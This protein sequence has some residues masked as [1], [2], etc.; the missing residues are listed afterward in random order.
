M[1]AKDFGDLRVLGGEKTDLRYAEG[2]KIDIGGSYTRFERKIEMRGELYMFFQEGRFLILVT[3]AVKP[4]LDR[5]KVVY[6]KIRKSIR[7]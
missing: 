6:D 4:G 3:M 2:F 7:F 1:S 5:Q